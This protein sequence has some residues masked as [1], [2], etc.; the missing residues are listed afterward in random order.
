MNACS[1]EFPSDNRKPVLSFAEGSPIQNPKW[2]GI[3]TIVVALTMCVVRAEAQQ[4]GKIF[5]IG[6][7]D[8]GT[9][10]GVAVMVDVFRQELSKHGWIEGKNIT[11]EYRF[12]EQKPERL[13][14]LAAELTSA[15]VDSTYEA[16]MH[17]FLPVA[18]DANARG[19]TQLLS[20]V[21]EYALP[22]VVKPTG[23]ACSTS[24]AASLE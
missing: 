11:I 6:F 21:F 18:R 3:C 5:R 24:L 9:A 17:V 8:P 13:P 20:R 10:S 23:K 19:D 1:S 15:D 16:W 22:L 4:P 12:G 2:V 14:E 7:L